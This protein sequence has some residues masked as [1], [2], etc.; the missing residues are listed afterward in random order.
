MR[1]TGSSA[2]PA[3]PEIARAPG[4]AAAHPV[5]ISTIDRATAKLL[6]RDVADADMEHL[7]FL[8]QL[9]HRP[10]RLLQGDVGIG[11][12]QLVEVDPVD[13]QPTQRAGSTG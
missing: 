11:L 3:P 4:R 1:G 2:A 10:D 12:L 9:S 5:A 13:L 8:Q 7:A 6:H